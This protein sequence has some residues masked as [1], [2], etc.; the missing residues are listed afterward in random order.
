MNLLEHVAQNKDFYEVATQI[1]TLFIA[2]LAFFVT[3]VQTY[4][5]HKH[6]KRMV[7]P[8]LGGQWESDHDELTYQYTITNNGLGPAIVKRA[9]YHFDGKTFSNPTHNQIEEILEKLFAPHD[10]TQSF[11]VYG[12]NEY[13]PKGDSKVILGLAFK[14]TAVDMDKVIDQIQSRTKIEIEYRSLVGQKF[15][16][17]SVDD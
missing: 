15:S 17:N 5:T 16:F 9:T 4:T 3:A 2:A 1:G 7:T 14:T 8:H 10:R 13:I 6:N 11:G 12:I